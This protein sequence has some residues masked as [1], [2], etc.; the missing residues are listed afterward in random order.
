MRILPSALACASLALVLASC[1]PAS[2]PGSD[3]APQT[4]TA[5]LTP[6][7]KAAIE[8]LASEQL[9]SLEQLV[10][11]TGGTDTATCTLA[12]WPT[13]LSDE[14]TPETLIT[15]NCIAIQ[16]ATNGA[17][18]GLSYTGTINPQTGEQRARINR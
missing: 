6:A 14:S 18:A 12:T 9:P 15:Y 17:A 3:N 16:D 2:T 7:D 4:P 5:G 10:A 13:R 11:D 1:A 8:T